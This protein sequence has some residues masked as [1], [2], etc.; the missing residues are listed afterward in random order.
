MTEG[1]WVKSG[2]SPRACSMDRQTRQGNGVEV[3]PGGV[4]GVSSSH[5][6]PLSII[7]T[8]S[9]GD[10]EGDGVAY[11]ETGPFASEDKEGGGR[12]GEEEGGKRSFSLMLWQMSPQSC[13][14][15]YSAIN[16]RGIT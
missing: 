14:A 7:L 5:C 10:G 12:D 4:K 11:V 15:M 8:G 2:Q 9:I 6:F 13:C 3:L 1:I 16:A